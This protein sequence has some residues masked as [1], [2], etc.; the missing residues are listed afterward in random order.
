MVVPEPV[1]RHVTSH[2]KTRHLHPRR[3]VLVVV[4]ARVVV[5]DRVGDGVVVVVPRG[6][7]DADDGGALGPDALVHARGRGGRALL[8]R[9]VGA[10]RPRPPLRAVVVVAV[11]AV[12]VVLVG[13]RRRGPA[14]PLQRRAASRSG[15]MSESDE[16]LSATDSERS[17][18]MG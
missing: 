1:A 15:A 8:P 18:H 3:D 17:Y 11:V 14:R 6:L 16:M 12:A 2:T 10:P 7:G 4:G 5:P 13:P 9:E